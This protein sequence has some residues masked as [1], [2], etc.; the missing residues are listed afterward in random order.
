MSELPLGVN[1]PIAETPDSS[2]IPI[3]SL[4]VLYT[5]VNSIYFQL[6]GQLCSNIRRTIH[7][8]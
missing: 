3:E 1:V 8:K 4:R 7:N 5:K 6:T 2:L